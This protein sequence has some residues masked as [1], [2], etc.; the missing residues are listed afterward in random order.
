MNL[1]TSSYVD[2]DLKS[3]ASAVVFRLAS[4]DGCCARPETTSAAVRTAIN[5][6]FRG[7]TRSPPRAILQEKRLRRAGGRGE[8]HEGNEGHEGPP[9]DLTAAGGGRG[10]GEAAPSDRRAVSE[11][12]VL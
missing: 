12:H 2:V 5:T 1:T 4:D 11:L 8:D 9:V 7:M 6:S 3:E 10:G